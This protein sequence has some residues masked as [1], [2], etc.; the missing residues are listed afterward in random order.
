MHDMFTKRVARIESLLKEVTAN[1]AASGRILLLASQSETEVSRL[2]AKVSEVL[3]KVV[4][5]INEAE[6]AQCSAGKGVLGSSIN[7]GTS[8]AFGALSVM[9]PGGMAMRVAGLALHI[10]GGSLATTVL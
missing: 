10:V 1:P 5:K 9:I 3:C 4:E 6:A 2:A 7:I 8:V